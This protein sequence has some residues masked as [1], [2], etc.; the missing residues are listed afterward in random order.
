MNTKLHDRIVYLANMLLDEKENVTEEEIRTQVTI[1]ISTFGV[2]ATEIDLESVVR[3]VEAMQSV[4]IGTITALYD[5][6]DHNP[7][8]LDKKSQTTWHFWK[9][10]ETHLRL[11]KKWEPQ[12]VDRLDE[13]TDA[14]LSATEDPD[15]EGVWDNRGMVVG[16]VQSGKTANYTGLV[17]K[18]IDAGYRLIIIMAGSQNSLRSQTQLRIDEGVLGFDT[19]KSRSLLNDSR[20]IGVGTIPSAKRLV[21]HPLT[22]SEE[23]GDFS[24]AVSKNAPSKIGEEPFI[25]VVKKYKSVLDNIED[26]AR[27]SMSVKNEDGKSKIKEI[28][29]MLIDDE[30]DNASINTKTV[31]L[32]DDG[33]QDADQDVAAIN[34]KIRDILSLFDKSSYVA[35]TATPFA[36]IFV[37]HNVTHERHEDDVF[38]RNF[39]IGLP[40]PE[41][42]IGPEEF[43]GINRGVNISDSVIREVDDGYDYYPLAHKKDLIPG[44]IP[45]SLENAILSF[46]LVCRLRA[47]MG[48]SEQHN[49][50]LVHVT[51]L[52]DVQKHVHTDVKS[53]LTAV[54]RELEYNNSG[55]YTERLEELYE[56]DFKATTIKLT[57][58]LSK[59]DHPR[60]ATWQEVQEKLYEAAVK[61]DVRS[62]NGSARD[63]L[64]YID[65]QEKGLSV[66]AVGGDKL[67]RGLTL[68]GLSISYFLRSSKTYDTLMQMGR[69]FGYRPGYMHLC[70]LYTP[71]DLARKYK[72]IAVAARHLNDQFAEMGE[73][74]ATPRDFGLR[75]MSDPDGQMMITAANKLKNGQ[76][77]Q[78]SYSGA[79]IET[80]HFDKDAETIEA[81]IRNTNM[82]VSELGDNFE[83]KGSRYLWRNI[84]PAT[85][86]KFL[87]SYRAH[88]EYVSSGAGGLLAEYIKKQNRHNELIDWSVGIISKRE[89]AGSETKS[90]NLGS[91]NVG[92]IERSQTE[93]NPNTYSLINSRLGSAADEGLD[94]SPNTVEAL[95]RKVKTISG[96][97]YRKQRQPKN[98]L[99]LLYV[100]DPSEI[101]GAEDPFIGYSVSFPS[102]NTAQ[103]VTFT[104]NTVFKERNEG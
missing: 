52:N 57:P 12:V 23:S 25:L 99:L 41:T 103:S 39:I 68:E 29:M 101:N 28:P 9:R 1:A 7:W 18:A 8:L 44:G 95:K 51:R 24:K 77:V 4:N 96:A 91:V 73:I 14:I 89:T 16:Q 86:T 56:K 6:T 47:L 61:I 100:L 93:D 84:N 19:K 64:D 17:C 3:E 98:G 33:V 32:N 21:A 54:R 83:R 2:S 76:K 26:W 69:W 20:P 74:G 66:I 36:N 104:V 15:R 82:L 35:Y 50:M 88:N 60:I 13:I 5:R 59:K 43:F 34:G 71:D 11:H 55:P 67:S 92:M 38:P 42:Y 80:K 45:K 27:S 79:L 31:R 75:V 37:D 58:V 40:A 46:I 87:S 97:V 94:L 102:S 22:T 72:S 49:S 48:Q 90:L 30:A 70:R 62:I 65:N 10:Y 85:I 63:A 81:N 53:F 78:I